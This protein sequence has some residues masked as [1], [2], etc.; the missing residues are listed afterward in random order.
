MVPGGPL[1]AHSPA[2]EGVTIVTSQGFHYMLVGLGWVCAMSCSHHQRYSPSRT[3]SLFQDTPLF[4]KPPLSTRN[5]YSPSS[6]AHRNAAGLS[7][8]LPGSPSPAQVILEV[9]ISFLQGRAALSSFTRYTLPALHKLLLP[10][11]IQIT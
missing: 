5:K 3:L 7:I 2:I 4:L 10:T 9:L 11:I 8:L 1:R 6:P